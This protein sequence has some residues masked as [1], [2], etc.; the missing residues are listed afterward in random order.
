[1]YTGKLI[2]RW[3]VSKLV[4]EAADYT[5]DLDLDEESAGKRWSVSAYWCGNWTRFLNHSCAPNLRVYPV[6]I[7]H[8]EVRV[9][10][11]SYPNTRLI[12]S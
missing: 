12:A 11:M 2:E 10:L 8:P 3:K 1:M 4:K 6:F 9:L 5:F 7:D